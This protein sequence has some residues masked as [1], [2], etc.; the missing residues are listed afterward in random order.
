METIRRSS[1][2]E[3]SPPPLDNLPSS[4]RI[5]AFGEINPGFGQILQRASILPEDESAGEANW[6]QRLKKKILDQFNAA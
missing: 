6:F 4:A 1:H 5:V 3:M 2:I